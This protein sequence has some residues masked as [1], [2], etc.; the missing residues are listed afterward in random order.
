MILITGTSGKP[1]QSSLAARTAS[2]AV[3]SGLFVFTTLASAAQAAP[4]MRKAADERAYAASATTADPAQRVTALDSFIKTYPKSHQI[5]RAR[6]LRL[7]TLI[8]YLPDHT[9]DLKRA[10]KD[11]IHSSDKGFGR[12]ESEAEIAERYA[13]AGP[14]GILLPEAE[15]LATHAEHHLDEAMWDS[16]QV[17]LYKQFKAPLPKPE[18]LHQH[19]LESTA[20]IYLAL[21]DVYLHEQRLAEAKPL[22]DKAYAI[23]SAD[24]ATNAIRAE[25]ALA[26]HDNSEAL[27]DFERAAVANDISE[28]FSDLAKKYHATLVQ[29]Y[30][31][32]NNG[33]DSG[34]D[35]ALDARYNELFPPPFTPE[36]VALVPPGHVALLELFT[37]SG[38]PP[39]IGGDIAVDA[40]L[41]Q[42]PRTDLIAL[43]FDEH[44]PRP[45]PLTNP[46][47]VARAELF[48][49]AHTPSFVL[50]GT[51]ISIY[52]SYRAESKDTYTDLQKMTAAEIA[53]PSNIK[54]SLAANLSAAGE[55]QVQANVTTGMQE[56][57]LK[58]IT[59]P[60][61]TSPPR[62]PEEAKKES[63][64]AKAKDKTQ[65]PATA[66]PAAAASVAAAPPPLPVPH[67][68][69]NFALAEDDVRYSG[70]NGIR[71]HRMVVRSLAKPADSGF[72]LE[73]NKTTTTD[74]SFN[75]AAI[76]A[77][78]H[79]YLVSYAK[80]NER[81]GPLE[82]RFMPTTMNPQHLYVVAWVQDTTTN[83]VLQSAIA[84]VNGQASTNETAS[85]ESN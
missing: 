46:D 21:A 75:M 69:V 84:S 4:T 29:L 67:L 35:A 41:A 2:V 1:F 55:I 3:F 5:G 19:Y 20:N 63:D 65:K 47:S 8:E 80:S 45:D 71:F 10:A 60:K 70:E 30:R 24:I 50:D 40:L 43:T 32:A 66:K 72:P 54:L 83:R 68:V 36:K 13:E 82:W 42:Y 77:K 27:T 15:K 79:D 11:E 49:A 51:Q 61:P 31:D 14:N 62:K 37:G 16:G 38:C 74:A 28:L 18:K 85:G 23:Q 6:S 12:L 25:Y 52:G 57:A 48:H 33:S 64:T 53:A 76:S 56:E 34:L 39:C 22:L 44:I 26:S 73:F 17:K 78:L 81:F 9:D 59:E 7:N 58:L